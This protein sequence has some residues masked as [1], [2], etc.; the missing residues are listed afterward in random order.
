M[1][2]LVPLLISLAA[3][4]TTPRNPASSGTPVDAERTRY[5]LDALVFE[6]TTRFSSDQAIRDEWR[7]EARVRDCRDA[8]TLREL[9]GAGEKHFELIGDDGE[10]VRLRSGVG[11]RLG[12]WG[13]GRGRQAFLLLTP[14]PRDWRPRFGVSYRLVPRNMDGA[15]LWSV[16]ESATLRL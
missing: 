6:R 9:T 15:H 2:S 7:V 14:N 11:G 13:D 1:R 3:C 8:E 12:D 4:A 16:A 5:E 10:A